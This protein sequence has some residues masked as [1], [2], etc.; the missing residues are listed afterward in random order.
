MTSTRLK[1]SLKEF[2][3]DWLPDKFKRIFKMAQD[4]TAAGVYERLHD[5]AEKSR[6]PY[7]HGG[8]DK[9]GAR[10]PYRAWTRN[11]TPDVVG[12][13]R[14]HP[15]FHFLPERETSFDEVTGLFDEMVLLATAEP[16]WAGY[17]M[18]ARGTQHL[19]RARSSAELRDRRCGR[20]RGVRGLAHQNE[21]H[22]RAVNQYGPVNLAPIYG[23]GGCHRRL[24]SMMDTFSETAII[25]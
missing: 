13:P 2:I 24:R 23:C 9:A 16:G 18:G 22:S 19:L 3:G 4:R 7:G 8:F 10:C 15:T 1:D 14:T 5:V 20:R 17:R 6:N 25:S 12:H 21:L 11:H